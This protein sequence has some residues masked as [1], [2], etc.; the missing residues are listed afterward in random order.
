MHAQTHSSIRQAPH[1]RGVSVGFTLIE[2]LVTL[3][4]T[5]IMM[6]MFALIFQITG[7]FVTRQK[8]IGE[9]DQSARILTT[10]LKTDLEARTMRIVAPFQPNPTAVSVTIDTQRQGYFY[11]S[12]NDPLNDQ[13]DVLQ[14]TIDLTK[15]PSANPAHNGQM[16]GAAMNLPLPWQPTTSYAIN[17]LVRPWKSPAT[18]Y[19]YK[20]TTGSTVNS[21]TTEPLAWDSTGTTPT[22]DTGGFNWTTVPSALDQPDGDDGV[23]S[24][25]TPTLS[26]IN[27]V[28][29]TNNTG[30]SHY[31]EVSYFLRHG[32]LYRRLLLIRNPYNEASLPPDSQP[33]DTSNTP[34]ISGSYANNFWSD[35]DYSARIEPGLIPG[36]KFHS[37][38]GTEN[39]LSNVVGGARNSFALGHPD[40]RFG[41]DQV[42]VATGG[43]ATNGRPREYDTNGIFFGRYT[44]EETS[45]SPV[46]LPTTQWFGFPGY[47]PAIGSPMAQSTNVTLDPT[48]SYMTQFHGGS[49][50]GE[51]ILLTNV[52]SFDV[53]ILDNSYS[54]YNGPLPLPSPPPAD[55]N[56]DG[57]IQIGPAPAFADL[58][59]AGPTGVFAKTAQNS[60]IAAYGPNPPAPTTN[61]VFDTWHP[62]FDFNGDGTYDPP[63]YTGLPTTTWVAGTAYGVGQVVI[64]PAAQVPPVINGMEY[65]CISAG[66][67]GAG[68]NSPFQNSDLPVN[69]YTPVQ[70]PTAPIQ[71]GSVVWVCQSPIPSIQITVKYLDPSQNLLRQVTIIQSF[72]LP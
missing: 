72:T 53:K 60:G 26:T 44:H 25:L 15:L 5:L 2:M 69:N 71:D 16:Y 27:P 38:L 51:D 1:R 41:H 64:P 42:Y 66:T 56:R 3:A 13:D 57:I 31:G 37:Y 28:T 19:V 48:G 43:G 45:Y 65:V 40:N 29:G 61:N 23:I 9:N 24:Y 18:G 32:N 36:V 10:T 17:A 11:Y 46:G 4:L 6:Y 70:N 54:E 20:N 33:Y 63:P 47:L 52:I 21:G 68:P 55:L 14:F 49:R 35:F 39:S 7:N 8:G 30:A 22:A 12:E 59:H 34:L 58:G 50:R 62:Q 67:S